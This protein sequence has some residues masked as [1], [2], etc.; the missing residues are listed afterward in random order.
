MVSRQRRQTWSVRTTEEENELQD[1]SND[2]EGSLFNNYCVPLSTRKSSNHDGQ[3]PLSSSWTHVLNRV[4]LFSQREKAFKTAFYNGAAVLFIILCCSCAVLAFYILE[5]FLRPILWAILTGAFLFPF[6]KTLTKITRQY[7]K[8]FEVNNHLLI[9]GVTIIVPY[10]TLDTL[11][12][13]LGPLAI[14]K[15]KPILF[16]FILLPILN[17]AKMDIYS[18]LKA[19]LYEIILKLSLIQEYFESQ[20][21]ITLLCGYLCAVIC[22]YNEENYIIKKIL[23]LLAIPLWIIFFLYISQYISQTYRLLFLILTFTLIVIGFIADVHEKFDIE[24]KRNKSS[25]NEANNREYILPRQEVFAPSPSH[26]LFRLFLKG[27]KKLNYCLQESIDYLISAFI[28]FTLLITVLFGAVVLAIQIHRESLHMIKLT[29]NLVNETVVLQPT[30]Q[31]LLPEKEHMNQ[32]V[33]TA[34]NNFYL[35]G[36]R[37]LA[38]QVQNFG[39]DNL[40][41]KKIE[42]NVLELWDRLYTYITISSFSTSSLNNRTSTNIL[43]HQSVPTTSLVEEENVPTSLAK[44]FNWQLLLFNLQDFDLTSIHLNDIYYLVKDNLGLFKSVFDSIWSNMNVFLTFMSTILS[45]LFHGGFV[46]FNFLFSFVVYIT[47]L[48]YLLSHSND[49]YRPNQWINQLGGINNV[50]LGKAV[51]DSI[52]SV[53]VASLK[54]ASFY[55]IY[56]Y[57]IHTIFGVNIVFL[58]SVIAAICA[59]CVKSYWSSLPGCLDLWLMQRQPV[60]ALL[61]LICQ[62][63]PTYFVDTAIYSEVKGGG[64]QYLTALAIAGGVYYRGLEGALIGPIVLCCLLVGV[65]LYETMIASDTILTRTEN[66]LKMQIVPNVRDDHPVEIL[67]TFQDRQQQTTDIPMNE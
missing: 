16:I 60:L 10:Q 53:F 21:I 43:F 6:K 48:F 42:E 57:L 5:A 20:W 17:V 30:F 51:N 62:I 58:P 7:L 14:Q 66:E 61:L 23:N 9:T 11:S 50:K 19:F 67:Q 12:N 31:Y 2:Q 1:G 54:M 8:Q 65:K 27:D 24:S 18:G 37:F 41:N 45:L 26:G 35:Y 32:L 22:L 36:R 15:W 52:T 28:I 59:V 33:D 39:Q 63:T 49:Y 44:K 56:T 13:Y 4:T 47:L 55:G 3:P 40:P 34:V 25:V 38:N 46:L 64:H 29:G